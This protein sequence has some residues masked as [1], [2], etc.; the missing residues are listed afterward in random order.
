M[1]ESIHYAHMKEG[2][3]V[4]YHCDGIVI[5]ECVFIKQDPFIVTI[6][7]AWYYDGIERAETFVKKKN[8]LFPTKQEAITCLINIEIKKRAESEAN[9]KKLRAMFAED[10]GKES[11]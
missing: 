3:T 8:M 4:Y 5:Q 2:D 6:R 11:A 7:H 9:T 1:R 10:D